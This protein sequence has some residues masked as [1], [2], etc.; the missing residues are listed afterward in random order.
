MPQVPIIP[1][2][3]EQPE[4][5]FKPELPQKPTDTK[6]KPPIVEPESPSPTGSI[7][8]PLVPGRNG[9][10]IEQGQAGPPGRIIHSGSGRP[11][12]AD[13]QKDTEMF[14]GFAGA[15]GEY[16]WSFDIFC[17][18]TCIRKQIHWGIRKSL[19]M[20]MIWV[21]HWCYLFPPNYFILF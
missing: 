5:P 7:V 10:I 13:G 8:I 17:L 4:Q 12:G 6:T 3:P 1:S 18:K 21:V 16:S 11:Q 2:I 20:I 14:K 19:D 15:P 9:I